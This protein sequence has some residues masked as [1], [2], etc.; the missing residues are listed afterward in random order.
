MYGKSEEK[1]IH[2]LHFTSFLALVEGSDDGLA[3]SISV[4]DAVNPHLSVQILKC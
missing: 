4:E 1:M 3:Q 2:L